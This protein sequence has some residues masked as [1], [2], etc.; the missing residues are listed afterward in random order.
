MAGRGAGRYASPA[1]DL[2]GSGTYA[3]RESFGRRRLTIELRPHWPLQLD[4]DLP[5]SFHHALLPVDVR[6]AIELAE[7][8]ERRPPR[9]VAGEEHI[10][11]TVVDRRLRRDVHARSEV[12]AVGR[13]DR[14]KAAAVQ[15]AIDQN[16]HRLR[17]VGGDPD[18][19]ASEVT[20][21]LARQSGGGRDALGDVAVD[22]D[23]GR[24]HEH[25]PVH[26]ADIDPSPLCR[27]DETGNVA[28]SPWVTE[29]AREIV[30]RADRVES[31]RGFASCAA[32]CPLLRA[33]VS[34]S[35]SADPLTAPRTSTR[36]S[37]RFVR[38]RGRTV[39]T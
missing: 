29:R 35:R 3:Y 26:L 23:A 16:A 1:Q 25:A 19:R 24:V 22:A 4:L 6:A 36:P 5:R 27:P 17:P 11:L 8:T 32:P 33:A 2:E 38:C 28:P 15:L 21:G 39:T 13:D 30:P 7:R 12:R 20:K 18:E 37:S 34:A 9:K 10:E 14:E 31:E